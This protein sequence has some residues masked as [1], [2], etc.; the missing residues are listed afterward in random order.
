[1]AK[2]NKV[3]RLISMILKGA[4]YESEG[5]K[6]AKEKKAKIESSIG[7]QFVAEQDRR[8]EEIRKDVEELRK[9]RKKKTTLTG[10]RYG[11]DADATLRRIKEQ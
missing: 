9:K 10:A 7:G 2:K 6:K 4:E 8:R 1:M 5:A 11:R 3:A